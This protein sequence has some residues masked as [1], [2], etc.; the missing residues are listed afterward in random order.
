MGVVRRTRFRTL[1]AGSSAQCSSDKVPP[2]H[3]P[4]SVASSCS[5]TR[6]T[7]RSAEGIS[8]HT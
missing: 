5:D 6:R 2:M 7:S 4:S 8:S 1:V 3:H